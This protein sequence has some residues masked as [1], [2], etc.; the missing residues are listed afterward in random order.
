MAGLLDMHQLAG[1]AQALTVLSKMADW[2]K[3]RVDRLT[4]RQRQ[5][6]LGTE[7]GGMNEVLTNL[8]QR[9]TGNPEYLRFAHAFDHKAI[10]DPLAAVRIR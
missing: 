4:R 9:S 2:V 6:T 5:E 7:F 8:Y 1:N 3:F 10:F